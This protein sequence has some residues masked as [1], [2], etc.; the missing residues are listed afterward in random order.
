M[1]LINFAHGE[2]IMVGGFALFYLGHPGW[3]LLILGTLG[4]TVAFALATERIA[5]RPVRGADP[6]TLLV[7]SFAVSFLLQNLA[8]VILGSVPK[9]TNLS[10]SLAE[11]FS[12]GG[13]D[14]GELDAGTAVATVGPVVAL[15]VVLRE[16][17]I[18]VQMFPTGSGFPMGRDLR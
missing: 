18:R 11:S 13:G 7:T 6:I 2:L 1:G 15:S 10:T 16:T 8:Q 12:I 4:I 14:I 5:F 3:P 9:T 17:P